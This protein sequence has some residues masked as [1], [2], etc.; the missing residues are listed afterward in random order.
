MRS[1]R[2]WIGLAAALVG[3]RDASRAGVPFLEFETRIIE[4]EGPPEGA[5][6]TRALEYEPLATSRARLDAAQ[7][8]ARADVPPALVDALAPAPL[9]RLAHV[10]D[11]H[12]R[13]ER[14]RLFVF[15][16]E[17]AELPGAS[18]VSPLQAGS[19]PPRLAANTAFMW[20]GLVM[21]LNEVHR[22]APLDVVI[23]SGDVADVNLRSELWRF[24]D[25]ARRLDPPLLL[26]PGNHDVLAWGVWRRGRPALGASLDEDVEVDDDRVAAT[27]ALNQERLLQSAG[28]HLEAVREVVGEQGVHAP[29]FAAFGARDFGFDLAPVEGALYYAV[30]LVP[31]GPDGRPGVL[32]VA[33][34]TNR[35]GGGPDPEIDDAQLAWLDE[36]LAE[37]AARGQVVVVVGHHPLVRTPRGLVDLVLPVDDLDDL[38]ASL[39]ARPEVALYLTGHTHEPEVHLLLGSGG[40]PALLQV[41]PGAL[42]R[43]PQTAAIVELSVEGDDLVIDARRVGALIAEGSTLAGHLQESRAGAEEAR[44]EGAPRP[45][46]PVRVRK[47][48]PG[49]PAALAGGR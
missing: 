24:L 33:L 14:A 5:V 42:I 12:V 28:E 1:L 15:G 31:P 44:V 46:D 30:D 18:L 27:F 40:A 9:L 4:A 21:T 7:A 48:L 23:H 6:V 29:T 39:L 49:R 20:L 25:V 16:E 47:R 36:R 17:A 43:P 34:D 3:C 2:V 41:N 19:R 10:A 11:V 13:E 38:R 8:G 35:R 45:W 22:Q 32:L 26:A 37:A